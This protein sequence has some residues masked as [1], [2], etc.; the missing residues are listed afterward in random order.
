MLHGGRV[1]RRACHEGSGVQTRA[2]TY[3][4]P[5]TLRRHC[6]RWR[7]RCGRIN[8]QGL[9]Q[10]SAERSARRHARQVQLTP[11]PASIGRSSDRR[12]VDDAGATSG[13]TC[14]SAAMP[15]SLEP[16]NH[17][18]Q[19]KS[20]HF[21]ESA[22]CTTAI[23]GPRDCR[24]SIWPPQDAPDLQRGPRRS[25]Y[26]E[27]GVG[28]VGCNPSSVNLQGDSV[29]ISKEYLTVVALASTG[30]G[31]GPDGRVNWPVIATKQTGVPA[32]SPTS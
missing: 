30:D 28:C 2:F 31:R 10:N 32:G 22:D 4:N 24:T 5:R 7:R 1:L 20:S 15:P 13:P 25:S 19:E 6:P 27:P 16:S 26:S 18:A 29:K 9:R 17:R 11:K 23:R 8:F 14:R 3:S 12:D 21:R